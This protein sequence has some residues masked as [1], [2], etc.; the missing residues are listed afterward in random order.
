[1]L[2]K[3]MLL[4]TLLLLTLGAPTAVTARTTLQQGELRWTAMYWDNV[5]LMGAPV[6]T[7]EERRI[8]HAWGTGSPSARVPVNRFSARWVRNIDVI[9]G[10]YQFTV[11]SDDGVRLWVD[12]ELILDQWMI[13]AAET[14][15]VDKYL[16]EGVHEVRLEYFENTG[17]ARIELSWRRAGGA[18]RGWDAAYFDNVDLTGEPILTR[19]E[20]TI[21][22]EWGT[23]SPAPGILG[24]DGFSARWVRTLDLTAGLYGFDLTTD[25]GARLWVD[26]RLLIDAWQDQAATTY[27][28]DVYI[29][30]GSTKIEVQYYER[31][32]RATVDL[33]WAPLSAPPGGGEPDA[34]IVDDTDPGFVRGGAVGDWNTA[35]DGYNDRLTWTENH[36]VIRPNYNWARWSPNL[37]AGRYEV[38]AHVP[39]RYS[40]T[41][42]AVYW[43]SH[44]GGFDMRV[45]DQRATSGEWVSLGTYQFAGT[46]TDYVV[47]SSV[48]SE[49]LGS[50]L[51]AFD[52]I[53]WE[54]R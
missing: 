42:R 54:A 39:F 31:T 40:T 29:S 1:M 6:L 16:T 15:T 14:F 2:R 24:T 10:A 23:G 26:G 22:H 32:G 37:E 43:I 44:S 21:D 25:D 4:G 28:A 34:V 8:Q 13:Q 47:L 52:A 5:D 7:R 11:T 38:F 50:R 45:I 17:L 51:V 35:A 49:T 9:P 30:G 20:A 46:S 12:G 33:D 36:D 19:N 18:E 3:C 41:E 48:T 53:R 27:E